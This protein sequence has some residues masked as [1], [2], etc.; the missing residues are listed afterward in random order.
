MCEYC[1]TTIDQN[2]DVYS[3]NCK[4]LIT[5]GHDFSLEADIMGDC[6]RVSIDAV[7]DEGEAIIWKNYF[8]DINYCPICGRVLNRQ[9]AYTI[10]MEQAKQQIINDTLIWGN[11]AF[12]FTAFKNIADNNGLSLDDYRVIIKDLESEGVISKFDNSGNMYVRNKEATNA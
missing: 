5:G 9:G 12:P 10:S 1:R 4:R 8:A 11:N 6:L 2:G 3:D 7:T